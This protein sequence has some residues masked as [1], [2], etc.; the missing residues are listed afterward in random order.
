[1]NSGLHP[2]RQYLDLL[3]ELLDHGDTRVDRTG[4]GT[5]ALFGRT[6][7]FD[8]AEGF[9]VFTTKRIFWKTAFKEMLWMLSGGRNIRELLQQNVRI[10]TDWPLKH[11]RES[12]GDLIS[13]E[14]FEAR[15]LEDEVFAQQWGDLG[16]VY[17]AQWRRWKASDGRE[18]DQ[19][20]ELVDSLKKN[21]GS[22]RLLFEG[23]NVGEL[24]QMALP[25]CHKTYQ[26]FVS[27]STGRLSGALMQ[28][29]ADAYLGLSWNVANLALLTHLLALEC[30]YTPGEIV[31]FG[32]DVHLYLNHQAQSQEQLT[33]SPRPWPELKILRQAPDLFSYCIDDFELE[34]YD[35][36]PHIAAD[37]AV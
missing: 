13:Q 7:R 20:S 12:T 31:W 10:W 5:R 11:Y 22:R 23:W 29:S 33:R 36:H 28:R 18:I 32:G 15:V 21:P 19:V 26:F 34:G 8:L 3:Q 25:P 6:L 16:P 30:G 17:G 2:E 37:V 4:V 14:A 35:P 24:D 1:M 9:P 27:E